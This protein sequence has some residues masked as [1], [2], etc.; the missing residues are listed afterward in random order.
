MLRL[1]AEEY[2]GK[3]GQHFD[4]VFKVAKWAEGWGATILDISASG[5]MAHGSQSVEPPSF[6]QGWRKHFAKAVKANVSV[7]V[8]TV[9]IIRDPA[10]AEWMLENGYCDLVG[11]AR[12][13]IADPDWANKA[14]AGCDK[15]I[16]HCISCMRCYEAISTNSGPI[17]CSVNPEAGYETQPRVPEVNGNGRRIGVIG[18]GPGGLTAA[19]ILA[20]RG[21][22]VTVYEKQPYLGGQ[23]W[24]GSRSTSKHKNMWLINTL[25]YR[26]RENGGARSSH[27]DSPDC[28]HTFFSLNSLG[29]MP[30]CFLKM[31]LK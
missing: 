17:R 20:K 14:K 25:E 31:R 10:Y 2:I 30:V 21:F 13:F 6:D 5:G 19:S 22:Q 26:C 3:N 7:P 27:D 29:V 15:D 23:V 18:G 28:S 12:N 8:S 16:M 9:A 24:L 1:S 11:S 4:E